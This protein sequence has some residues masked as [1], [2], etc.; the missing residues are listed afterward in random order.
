MIFYMFAESSHQFDPILKVLSPRNSG[1]VHP[2]PPPKFNIVTEKW[3][4][5]DDPFLLGQAAYFQRLC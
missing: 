1:I 2:L 5:E 3:W 4:L